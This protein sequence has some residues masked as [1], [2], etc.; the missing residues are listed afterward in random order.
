MPK[1][2]ELQLSGA[3]KRKLAKVKADNELESDLRDTISFSDIIMI[4]YKFASAKSR[5]CM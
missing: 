5:K 1:Q 3:K 2:K 4:I